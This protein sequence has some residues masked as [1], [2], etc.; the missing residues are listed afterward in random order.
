MGLGSATEAREAIVGDSALTLVPTFVV[1]AVDATGM[2]IILPLL[3]FYSQRLGATPFL[4]GALISVYAVCQLIA[5]P[6][7]GILSDRYGRRKVL[8]VS[9]IGTLIGFVLLALAGN[10]TLVFL[11]RIIDGLTSGN[12]SVAHAYAAE[13]S[14]PATR[15]QALG[16]TSG[17]IG[18]GLLLGPALSSFLVHYGQTAPVWA[19][20]ALSLISIF[21]TIAL[22][23]PDHPA[24][25]P[26]YHHRVPEP[27]LTLS[28]LGMRYA[29]RLLGLLIV[30]FFVNSMFLSQIGL[31]L[32]ARFSWDGHPFGA[33]ELGWMFAYAGFINMVVQGLLITRANLIASDRSI[34][35]AAFACMGL[36]FAG[37]A[38]GSS[39]SL[40]AIYLTLIIIGTMF[41]RSTL[42]A[43]L[44]RST[45]INRQ[46]MIMGLNQSLMSGANITAPLLSGA[47][48]GHRMF[49]SWAL[50][51]AAI[52]AI[53]A[54]LAGQL[55]DTPR[56]R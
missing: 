53:G 25:E 38:A 3:P 36:G 41:A 37:L 42:T 31:F 40:L 43:E 35:M 21:A 18:T 17:A 47:L 12:I 51:M 5:G 27:T 6:V 28:L 49:V 50:A 4:I 2:G 11:A 10:L 34:V 54:A 23:P 13:H 56:T 15:K 19:A 9:Q 14:A 52:A 24:S 46:G 8:V 1:V 22:L 26:L 45:A 33:R 20:A 44:S 39:V 7:V 55:L 16:M 48:I 29:W 30:F 32:S